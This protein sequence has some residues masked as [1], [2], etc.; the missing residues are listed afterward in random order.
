MARTGVGGLAVESGICCLVAAVLIVLLISPDAAAESPLPWRVGDKLTDG[1]SVSAEVRHSE[2]I[3]LKMEN[4]GRQ[5]EIEI[6]FNEAGP[7][8][9]ATRHYRVQPA[10]GSNPPESLLISVMNTLRQFEEQNEDKPFVSR[11]SGKTEK[12]PKTTVSAFDNM[13]QISVDISANPVKGTQ[14]IFIFQIIFFPLVALFIASLIIKIIFYVRKKKGGPASTSLEKTATLALFWLI[15]ILPVVLIGFLSFDIYES[16][17]ITNSI[18]KAGVLEDLR[19]TLALEKG[20]SFSLTQ[21]DG[22]LGYYRFGWTPLKDDSAICTVPNDFVPVERNPEERAIYIFGGSPVL[23]PD[24]QN[25]MVD[26]V[27]R[28]LSE[29]TGEKVRSYNFGM[30]GITC[31]SVARRAIEALKVPPDLLIIYNGV[32]DYSY[33][34]NFVAR[35]YFIAREGTVFESLLY[36]FFYIRFYWINEFPGSVEYKYAYPFYK[37]YFVEPVLNRILRDT[38]MLK[39]DESLF[40]AGEN[41]MFEHYLSKMSTIITAAGEAGVPVLIIPATGNFL[42]RPFGVDNDALNHYLK[43]LSSRDYNES[44]YHM[45]WAREGSYFNKLIRAKHQIYDELYNLDYPNLYVFDLEYELL[46]AR[47]PFDFTS[48]M[49]QAHMHTKTHEYIS[50]FIAS[51]ILENDLCCSM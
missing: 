18:D 19:K 36:L 30:C 13:D 29:R 9:W 28:E 23:L 41:V 40:L 8:E 50:T 46:Q 25:S 43:G 51:Y 44:A 11:V 10:K 47:F 35:N 39:V 2:Y 6:V 24:P 49:D 15:Q 45:L 20:L 31:T 14:T 34:D 7:G 21:K 32:N 5:V 38:N 26:F 27:A 12:K 17:R 3:L 33:S 1:W 4:A 37:Q 16:V 22:Q 42:E 48:Y